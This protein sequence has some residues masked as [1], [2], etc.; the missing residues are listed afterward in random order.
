MH[1][2]AHIANKASISDTFASSCLLSDYTQT[3]QIFLM[4]Y[5]KKKKEKKAQTDAKTK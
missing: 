4:S 1:A 2:R 5:K 3:F